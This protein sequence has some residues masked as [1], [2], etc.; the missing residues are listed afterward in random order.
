MQSYTGKVGRGGQGVSF[1]E[2]EDEKSDKT[3][4]VVERWMD[5]CG[6]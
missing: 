5:R 2:V 6:W 3:R 1:E 4:Y